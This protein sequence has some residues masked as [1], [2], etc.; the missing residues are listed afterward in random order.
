MSKISVATLV[1][2]LICAGCIQPTQYNKETGTY[3]GDW[4]TYQNRPAAEYFDGHW[5]CPQG[6]DVFEIQSRAS[7]DEKPDAVCVRD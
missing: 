1:L 2:I 3:T 5:N 4:P 6:W 7:N